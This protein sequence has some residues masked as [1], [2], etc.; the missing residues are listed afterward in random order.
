MTATSSPKRSGAS[1]G[2]PGVKIFLTAAS[3]TSIIGGWAGFTVQQSGLTQAEASS[4]TTVQAEL[5]FP[6]MPTLVSAPGAIA[7]GVTPVATPRPVIVGSGSGSGGRQPGL[8]P[9]AIRKPR[10]PTTRTRSSR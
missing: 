6:P 1:T 5:E 2:G 7:T 3:L 10:A 8:P 4:D 9:A